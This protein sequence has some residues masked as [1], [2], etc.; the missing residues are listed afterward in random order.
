VIACGPAR[1][2]VVPREEAVMRKHRRSVL[3][4]VSMCA[5]LAL[6]P[7]W[8]GKTGLAADP[9]QPVKSLATPAPNCPGFKGGGTVSPC[10]P[11]TPCINWPPRFKLEGDVYISTTTPA[12]H[13]RDR[14]LYDYSDTSNPLMKVRFSRCLPLPISM[15]ANQRPGE[16]TGEPCTFLFWGGKL[17]L[18]PAPPAAGHTKPKQGS[19]CM[20]FDKSTPFFPP[21]PGFPSKLQSWATHLPS[22]P[23]VDAPINAHLTDLFPVAMGAVCGYYGVFPDLTKASD[24]QP[25]IWPASFSAE[26][27]TEYA[28]IEFT[29]FYPGAK[30][31]KEQFALPKAC[32]GDD[33]P[34]CATPPLNSTELGGVCASCHAHSLDDEKK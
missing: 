18:W 19:C 25:W 1:A 8:D 27:P 7:G 2:D 33:V 29:D 32:R 34:Y 13:A 31:A 26:L 10:T 20:V 22:K 12:A 21:N 16:A 17:Y 6:V 30:I 3:L 15:D 9:E 5:L 4:Q 11:G 23:E 14:I 24:G 28:E